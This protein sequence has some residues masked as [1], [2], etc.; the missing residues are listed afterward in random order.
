MW[1]QDHTA[2]PVSILLAYLFVL[3]QLQ[4]CLRL[5][6]HLHLQ[7]PVL[8]CPLFRFQ[9]RLLHDIFRRTETSTGQTYD[10]TDMQTPYLN[11]MEMWF[12]VKR[13]S[14]FVTS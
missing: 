1:V 4:N 12:D 3:L 5:L 13:A 8:S 14:V 2:I 6:S 7:L 9:L 11:T 10:V